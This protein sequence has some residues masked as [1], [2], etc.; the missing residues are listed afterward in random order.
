VGLF[1]KVLVIQERLHRHER[2]NM[3]LSR[4]EEDQMF[5]KLAAGKTS[6]DFGPQRIQNA[7]H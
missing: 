4:G 7:R 2:M 1:R 5:D 3:N 6:I